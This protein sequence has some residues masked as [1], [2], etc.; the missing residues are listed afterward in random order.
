[1][2]FFLGAFA[3]GSEDEKTS[4]IKRLKVVGQK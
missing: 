1:M 4:K 3:G 2:R